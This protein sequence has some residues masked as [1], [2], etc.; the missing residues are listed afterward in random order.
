[1]EKK[2]RLKQHIEYAAQKGALGVIDDFLR[3]LNPDQ[4]HKDDGNS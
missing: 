4:W 1:M 2:M 3:N